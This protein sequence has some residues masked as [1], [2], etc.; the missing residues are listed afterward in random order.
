MEGVALGQRFLLF[1]IC[2]VRRASGSKGQQTHQAGDPNQGC[3]DEVAQEAEE[4]AVLPP[5]ILVE[6]PADRTQVAH[7]QALHPQDVVLLLCDHFP[8]TAMWTDIAIVV[9]ISDNRAF[10]KFTH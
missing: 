8:C 5:E 2:A 4:A 10:T 1:C 6:N 9:Q 7:D 3:I